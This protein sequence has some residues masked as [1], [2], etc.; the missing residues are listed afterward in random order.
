MTNNKEKM[1]TKTVLF[2]VLIGTMLVPLHSG[3]AAENN[4]IAQSEEVKFFNKMKHSSNDK[5]PAT[6]MKYDLYNI[7]TNLN[8]IVLEGKVLSLFIDGKEY[9]IRLIED[10]LR[11]TD[12]KAFITNANGERIEVPLEPVD[13]YSGI[14]LDEKGRAGFVV[15]EEQMFGY[16]QINDDIINIEPLSLYDKNAN[17]KHYVF[18][19]D[20]DVD[21]SDIN[22]ANDAIPKGTITGTE[23]DGDLERLFGSLTVLVLDLFNN[24]PSEISFDFNAYAASNNAKILLDC[25]KEFY[26]INTSNWQTR[27]L[28]ELNQ[29]EDVYLNEVNID[30]LVASQECDVTNF[31]LQ[32][33]DVNLLYELQDRWDD[34]SIVRH[35]VHLSSGK[36]ITDADGWAFQDGSEPPNSDTYGYALSEHSSSMSATSKKFI[37]AQEIGH[38]MGGD[39]PDSGPSDDYPE[40]C[41]Q[42]SGSTCIEEKHTILGFPFTPNIFEFSDGS[43]NGTYDNNK[44]TITNNGNNWL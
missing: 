33:T 2:A 27:Q 31:Q 39:H 17:K 7:D 32:S 20:S 35:M 22:L 36:S 9:K 1:T 16:I 25:D 18:Y 24:T 30:F 23:Y 6:I 8:Q 44:Q 43:L 19:K 12:T 3:Y 28:N 38:L 40:K 11:T 21:T 14:I 15:N 4:G 41:T 37:M 29:I 13:V 5:I 42:F 34:S 26:Q 10:Q